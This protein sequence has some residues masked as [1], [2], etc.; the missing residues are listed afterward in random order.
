MLATPLSM[1]VYAVELDLIWGAVGEFPAA[2]AMVVMMVVV[3]WRSH[4]I[5]VRESKPPNAILIPIRI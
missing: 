3:L 1:N 2:A 4:V 5:G